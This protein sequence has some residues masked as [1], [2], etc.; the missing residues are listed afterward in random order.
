MDYGS[1]APAAVFQQVFAEQ[2]IEITV[3]Q[4]RE[5]MG[6][7]KREHISTILQMSSVR[8]A[9]RQIH[10][11]EFTE[12][13]IDEI[14]QRFLPLQLQILQSMRILSPERQQRLMSA[15]RWV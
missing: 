2:G 6:M 5:P 12:A 3:D 1:C 11:R 8:A 14:Y 13:D 7:A 15:A 10:L 9:W 4:A